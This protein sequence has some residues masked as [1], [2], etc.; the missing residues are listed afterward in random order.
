M[1]IITIKNVLK[2]TKSSKKKTKRKYY[3][4]LALNHLMQDNPKI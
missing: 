4:L 1:I 2:N 3:V